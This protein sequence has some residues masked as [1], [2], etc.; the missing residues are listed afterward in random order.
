M[1]AQ[2]HTQSDECRDRE[3][4]TREKNPRSEWA[5]KIHPFEGL[6]GQNHQ[7]TEHAK[8]EHSGN[9]ALMSGPLQETPSRHQ[10]QYQPKRCDGDTDTR[11][12]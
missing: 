10:F 4:E 11:G 7:T 5:I 2:K 12:R 1:T 8:S 6:D 3:P 9:R